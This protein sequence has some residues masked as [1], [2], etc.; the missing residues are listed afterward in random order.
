[1]A[2]LIWE[3]IRQI[4]KIHEDYHAL[5]KRNFVLIED[6]AFKNNF[7]FCTTSAQ[8]FFRII[9]LSRFFVQMQSLH[10]E[11]CANFREKFGE[12]S[13]IS[14]SRQST[15]HLQYVYEDYKK[16]VY[17]CQRKSDNIHYMLVKNYWDL[18]KK[19][20]NGEYN[21]NQTGGS[22]SWF[23]TILISALVLVSLAV[24]FFALF[25]PLLL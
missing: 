20:K 6:G 24:F 22:L 1:M 18:Q 21:P 25:K 16:E 7:F 2:A 12:L 23:S 8:N 15:T 10:E 5:L 14:P 4:N 11:C 17:R 13:Q 3:H 19:I 9:E